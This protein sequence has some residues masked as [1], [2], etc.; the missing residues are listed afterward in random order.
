MFSSS[1]NVY[2]VAK[3]CA[4]REHFY[5]AGEVFGLPTRERFHREAHFFAKPL[6]GRP[7]VRKF[8]RDSVAVR[9]ATPLTLAPLRIR[10]VR[11]WSPERKEFCYG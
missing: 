9:C 3:A 10:A 4:S 11:G 7:E 5:T 8:L 2:P 6:T 1:G